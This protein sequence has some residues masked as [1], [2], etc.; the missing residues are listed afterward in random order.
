MAAIQKTEAGG[1]SPV[2]T[3][4]KSGPEGMATHPAE[5]SRKFKFKERLSLTVDLGLIWNGL[6]FS[7]YCHHNS[8]QQK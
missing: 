6:I 5:D 7:A 1:G 3:D 2:K 4:H 8:H